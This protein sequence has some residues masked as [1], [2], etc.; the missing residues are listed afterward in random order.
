MKTV[1]LVPVNRSPVIHTNQRVLDA[2]LAEDLDVLMACGGRGRCA[3]CH[4]H[5]EAGSECLSPPTEREIRTL[6]RLSGAGSC[7]RLACQARV[8]REGVQVRL[9]KGMYLDKS[10]NIEDLIGKRAQERILHPLTGDVLV[11]EGKLITRSFIMQLKDV[12]MNLDAIEYD[13]A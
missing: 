5:I 2:L 1:S 10:T 8:L 12:Q 6:R 13:D 4:V 3:T 9:P 7:S 11:E